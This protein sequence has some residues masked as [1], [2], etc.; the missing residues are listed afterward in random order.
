MP[1]PV[2]VAA[3]A[4][5]GTVAAHIRAA[6]KIKEAKSILDET[7]SHYMNEKEKLDAAWSN[8]QSM[9]LALSDAK[10]QM[11]TGSMKEFMKTYQQIKKT[12]FRETVGMKEQSH[13]S[14][15]EKDFP[16]LRQLTD[17]CTSS[18]QDDVA[19][20]AL[21]AVQFGAARVASSLFAGPFVA[22]AVPALLFKGISD[23]LDAEENLDQ[24]KETRAKTDLAIEQM[25]NRERLCK[26][27]ADRSLMFKELLMSLNEMLVPC[28]H[29]M[30]EVVQR[31]KWSSRRGRTQKRLKS[32]DF[33]ENEMRLIAT[34][35]AIAG[36]VKA[37]IDTPMLSDT[38]GETRITDESQKICQTVKAEIPKLSVDVDRLKTIDFTG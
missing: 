37:V 25:Q 18:E 20:A 13:F 28:V 22:I 10:K 31:K 19:N 17:R 21:A 26:G 32:A 4:L 38:S 8:A 34:T 2:I 5:A 23:M 33:T 1:L 12:N 27:I 6:S 15:D 9:L 7:K 16:E 36:A 3:A 11:L 14:I 29:L 24:A 35:R 30:S